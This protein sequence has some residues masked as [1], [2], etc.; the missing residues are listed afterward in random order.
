MCVYFWR[1]ISWLLLEIYIL[2]G[3][4]CKQE[5]IPVGCVLPVAVTVHG[6]ICLSACWDTQP[7]WVWAGDPH[8]RHVGIPPPPLQGMLGYH[9]E[10]MLGYHPRSAR[11]AGIPPAM[12]AG[13]PPPCC[14]VWWDTTCNACW[15]TTTPPPREQNDRQVSL[16]G[17]NKQNRLN[18]VFFLYRLKG[19]FFT[20]QY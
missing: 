16:A 10:G 1:L 9:L 8:A 20:V 3:I 13:I 5:C 6:G 2:S 14:K 12:H 7:P 19:R 18:C 11:Y 17:G 4:W 15:D